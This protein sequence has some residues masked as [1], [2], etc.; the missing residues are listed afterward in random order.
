MNT[1][2]PSVEGSSIVVGGSVTANAGTWTGSPDPSTSFQWYKCTSAT[3]TSATVPAACTAIAGATANF[4]TIQ[5]AYKDLYLAVRVT[6]TNSA[7]GSAGAVIRMSASTTKVLVEPSST[8]AVRV[9]SSVTADTGAPIA[10]ATLTAVAGTWKGTGPFTITQTVLLATLKPGANYL[11]GDWTTR[12]TLT[13]TAGNVSPAM[14]DGFTLAANPPTISIATVAGDNTVNAAEASGALPVAGTTTAEPGQTV[15]VQLM[16]GPTV[17]GTYT[18]VVQPDGSYSLNIPQASIPADGN[19]SLKADVSNAAGTAA[20]QASQ[21]LT[22]DKTPPLISITSVAGNAIDATYVTATPFT[23]GAGSADHIDVSTGGI[24]PGI[25]IPT[26]PGYQVKFAE[27][28]RSKTHIKTNAVGQITDPEQAN[29]I[30]SS[31]KADAVML[32]REFMRDP[33]FPLR[34]STALGYKLPNWPPQ[35]LRAQP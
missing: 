12:S 16:N 23:L 21:A 15:T 11:D 28:I 18:T 33:H 3:A 2:A 30:V 8:V 9:S 4:L 25:P 26:G 13:D 10:G 17:L 27:S 1:V 31:G 7:V 5:D 34:A 19:Y 20:A 24:A 35:Y 22:V 32:G 14:A 29:Q 6:A